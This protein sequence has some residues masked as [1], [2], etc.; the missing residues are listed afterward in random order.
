[1]QN[2]R[3][4][5]PGQFESQPRF[6]IFNM[7]VAIF[8]SKEL[9]SKYAWFSFLA[10]ESILNLAAKVKWRSAIGRKLTNEKSPHAAI[11][12]ITLIWHVATVL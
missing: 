1:M 10:D 11:A 8:F 3:L 12:D 5:C 4:A 9:S 2:L 7:T 6:Q